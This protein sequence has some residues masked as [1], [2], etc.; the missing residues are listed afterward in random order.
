[1]NPRSILLGLLALGAVACGSNPNKPEQQD[2]TLERA[3]AIS[4]D[5]Q[6]GMNAKGE[7]VATRK[8]RLADQLKGLQKEVYNLEVEIYGDQEMGR[9]GLYGILRRCL[10]EGDEL[11]RLPARTI[12]T[13]PEDD[14]K[15]KMVIDE[16][17]QLVNVS[18]EYF[19]ERIKRFEGYKEAYLAQKDDFEEKVRICEHDLKRKK[20]GG[21]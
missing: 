3:E 14:V 11:K 12:L 5:S 16:H 2:T 6:V 8:V 17:D 7:V 10:D 15:G 9:R 21:N 1:M 13:R 4:P 20:S 18:E 19:L